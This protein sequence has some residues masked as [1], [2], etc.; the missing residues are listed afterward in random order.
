MPYKSSNIRLPEK[1]D[2]RVKLTAEDKDIIRARYS[3][4]ESSRSLGKEYGV[5]HKT[6]LLIVNPAMKAANDQRIKEHWR[7][8]QKHGEEWNAVMKEH[9]CY[10]ESLYR[11]GLIE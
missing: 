8:Y 7:E 10:K 11:K 2:R 4:G 3:Q 9:R 1:L 5:C 6:I